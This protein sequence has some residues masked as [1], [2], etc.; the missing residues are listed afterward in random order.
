MEAGSTQGRTAGG[1]SGAF[2]GFVPWIIFW[3]VA[4]PS[5]WKWAALAALIAAVVLAVP[6]ASGPGGLKLLDLGTIAFFA[7]I[8]LLALFLDRSGLDWLEKYAQVISSGALAVIAFASLAFMP[9]TEQ[10][11][12]ETAPREVWNTSGFKVL[13]RQLT[14]MWALVFALTAVSGLI[15]INVHSGRDFFEWILPL[16]L[17]VGALRVQM[18]LVGQAQA[19]GRARARA[20]PG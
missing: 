18:R 6:D 17:I 19:R 1:G 11:A 8:C 3:V 4:D 5:T 7:L 15:A 14:L 16:I 20:A 9:F 13:N 10:Y 2:I 12:R